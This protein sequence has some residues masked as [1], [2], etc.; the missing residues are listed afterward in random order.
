MRSSKLC[1][2]LTVLLV[3]LAAPALAREAGPSLKRILSMSDA[4]KAALP[5]DI[6]ARA[7]AKL[8]L[9]AVALS[10]DF[11]ARHSPKYSCLIPGEDLPHR[12]RD[13]KGSGRC[14]IYATDRV[15]RSLA[16]KNGVDAPE[17]ST[18]FVNYFALRDQA[19][20]LLRKA[21]DGDKKGID[22][23]AVKDAA[24]EGGYQPWALDIIREHGFVPKRFMG[25]SADAFSSGVAI[26]ELQRLV[27]GA[28][29]DFRKV[30]K[31]APDAAARRQAIF[32]RYEGEV[33]ALLSG[34]LGK[35]PTEFVFQGKRYTPQSF[36]ADYLRLGPA[37]LDFVVLTHQ[38]THGFM[39]ER[40][41]RETG[42][43]PFAQ[44]NVAMPVLERA[45]Q[46]TIRRGEAVYVATNVSADNPYRAD[47]KK[48]ASAKGILSLAAFNYGS[49]VPQHAI[50]K[51]DRMKAGIS[52]ANH[53]MAITGFDP[54]KDSVR[55]WLVENSWGPR[56]G[57]AGH[58]HMYDDYFR[59]YV[60]SVA[61]PRAVVPQEILERCEAH[62]AK[63]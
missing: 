23:H 26:N 7:V 50:S 56:A 18:S 36:L 40:Q 35:P 42:M 29:E 55:K 48:T 51:H 22:L 21:A 25:S 44:Y 58:W 47:G 28:Q 38:P 49:F 2:L 5:A 1:W 46:D 39:K 59:E 15:L 32:T 45:V 6:K 52:T 19:L 63:K 27:V 33:D 31:S 20:G 4:E 60:E 62:K 9:R 13:Q 34:T 10:N 57:A 61:V 24:S 8:G 43:K 17:M 11:V 37:D 16:R 54:E 53:A 12:I 41:V 14:W 30:G 3:L